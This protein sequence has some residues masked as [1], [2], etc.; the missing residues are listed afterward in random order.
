MPLPVWIERM[1]WR[2]A[3]E[4]ASACRRKQRGED[5][6]RD[7]RSPVSLE[8][9]YSEFLTEGFPAMLQAIYVTF[10]R[11]DRKIMLKGKLGFRLPLLGVSGPRVS[12]L[13]WR[14]STEG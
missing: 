12:G 5:G 4:L 7:V 13:A 9:R 14:G 11:Q 6:A 10:M 2:I 3:N 1:R 8:Q